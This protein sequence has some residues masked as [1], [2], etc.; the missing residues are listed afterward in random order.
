MNLAPS[1]M[2]KRLYNYIIVLSLITVVLRIVLIGYY[3]NNF[4]GIETNVVYG[5]QR[6]LLGQP[7]YQNPASGA[8]AVMQYTPL[9]YLFIAGFAKVFHIAGTDVQGVYMLC[10]IMALAFNL[11]TV[12]VAALIIRRW[13]Y[14]WQQSL[15]CALPVVIALTSHY[16]TRGDSMHLFFFVAAIYAYLLYSEKER[17][18][19]VF[20]AAV[21]TAACIMAKQSGVLAIGIISASL[22][23]RK[24]YFVAVAYCI[25]TLLLCY[26]LA[27]WCVGGQWHAFYQN[28]YLGLKNG[29]DFSWLY[30]IFVNQFYTDMVPFYA[31]GGVIV[32]CAFREIKDP[33]FRILATGIVLS[34]L[35]AV[36]TGL[37]NGSSNNYFVEFLVLVIIALPALFQHPVISK[38]L[39]RPFSYGVTVYRFAC[40]A[41]FI[42][43]TSKTLGF[44]TA[45]YIDKSIKNNKAEY[46]GEQALYRYFVNDLKIQ[47]GQRILFTERNF[48]DNI[49]IEYAIMPT[50]DVVSETYL[51]SSSTFDY[52]TFA[53]G[54]N[55]GLIT[56][57]VAD[58]KKLDINRWQEQIP[59]MKID[60]QKFKLIGSRAGYAIFKYMP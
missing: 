27:F 37:K 36:I 7:L 33:R 2:P 31:L 17:L 59:F 49:F 30:K 26:L 38:I 40:F 24:D 43:V 53:A 44:F 1:G 54:Q 14:N 50:K 42:L 18:Y 47:S 58:E 45:V 5:I 21:L 23:L 20:F 41:L 16:Y 10:R 9:W 51:A 39:F 3:N 52:S 48:L 11:L 34:W 56:Y 8:Y 46:A 29:T 12:L 60:L 19:L 55:N 25:G 15:I 22:L 32:F 4:G 35:F 13:G 6:L 28:A 57:I